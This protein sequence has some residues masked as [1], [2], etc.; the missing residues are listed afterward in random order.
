MSLCPQQCSG[1]GLLPCPAP[2]SPGHYKNPVANKTATV[3]DAA[4]VP[5][6]LRQPSLCPK[7]GANVLSPIKTFCGGCTL[8]AQLLLDRHQLPAS[9]WELP[10]RG[11]LC[12]RT[13]PVG[14]SLGKRSGKPLWG[15]GRVARAGGSSEEAGF[16]KHCLGAALGDRVGQGSHAQGIDSLLGKGPWDLLFEEGT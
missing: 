3:S 11:S 1:Q 8:P 4:G 5:A 9:P 2:G 16:G 7:A 15:V 6:S 13:T 14:S 10:G 12:P